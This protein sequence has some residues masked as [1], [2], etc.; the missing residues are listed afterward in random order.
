[1]VSLTICTARRVPWCNNAVLCQIVV[2]EIMALHDSGVPVIGFC[3]MPDHVH[4][5]VST[6]GKRLSE[7]V[8]LFKGRVARRVRKEKPDMVVW[9]RGY[10]DHVVRRN[11]GVYRTLEYIFQNP[12]RAGL[13]EDWWEF[14]WLGSPL[15]GEVGEG[16]FSINDHADE[17][18][19]TELIESAD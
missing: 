4:L 18:L 8:R 19:W 13:V 15:L 16:L 17:I 10:F 2:D 3:V 7:I 11:T 14:E 12:V 9:Q 6:A 5:L 1:V